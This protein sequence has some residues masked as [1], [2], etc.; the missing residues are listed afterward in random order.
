MKDTTRHMK[1]IFLFWICLSFPHIFSQKKEFINIKFIIIITLALTT[2]TSL[3]WLDV[4]RSL[5]YIVHNI[6]FKFT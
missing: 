3:K 4:F 6:V 5:P 1:E 2:H